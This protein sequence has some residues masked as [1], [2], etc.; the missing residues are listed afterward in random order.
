MSESNDIETEF[1]NIVESYRGSCA[2]LTCEDREFL[3]TNDLCDRLDDEIFSCETC[4]WWCE[5]SEESE[6]CGMCNQCDDEAN[7]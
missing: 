2:T 6:N 7:Q 3:E 4:G 1:D 5:K